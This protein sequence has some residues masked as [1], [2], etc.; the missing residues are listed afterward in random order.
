MLSIFLG[1]DVFGGCGW[2]VS[3]ELSYPISGHA[4]QENFNLNQKL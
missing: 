3:L 1:Y 2:G 4:S